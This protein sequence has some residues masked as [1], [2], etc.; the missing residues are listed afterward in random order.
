MNLP[1]WFRVIT[2]TAADG[3]RNVRISE[4]GQRLHVLAYITIMPDE[5]DMVNVWQHRT[6]DLS[7]GWVDCAR[8]KR[9]PDDEEDRAAAEP[10]FWSWAATEA[11]ESMV[12]LS[13]TETPWELHHGD[14]SDTQRPSRPAMRDGLRI[15]RNE[16]MNVG[17]RVQLLREGLPAATFTM[18]GATSVSGGR[19][20]TLW[21]GAGRESSHVI[22]VACALRP[23]VLVVDVAQGRKLLHTRV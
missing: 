19:R 12:P 2:A 4:D 6:V 14:A 7:S 17:S 20:R 13:R 10:G 8:Y 21:V 9:A 23:S 11:Q 22:I 16:R 15:F 5:G 3:V 1:G 18:S